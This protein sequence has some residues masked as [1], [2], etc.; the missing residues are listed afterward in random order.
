[1]SDNATPEG[2]PAVETPVVTDTPLEKP[3]ETKVYDE[4]YVKSLRDEAAA[5]RIAKKTAVEAA[6]KALKEA[7]AAEIAAKDLA[8]TELQ[9]ELGSAWIELEKVYTAVEAKV[10]S[11]KVR[12]FVEIL[13]GSDAESISESA[14]SRLELIGGFDKKTPAYDPSQGSGGKQQPLALNGDGI[15]NAMMAVLDKR[16]RR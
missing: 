2:T 4:T 6:E 9:N 1:M 12:A 15:L 10:P 13:E 11:D 16:P 14:K 3:A 5:A 8:Y 7:H